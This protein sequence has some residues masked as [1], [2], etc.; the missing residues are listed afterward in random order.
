MN[1]IF[2][3][4]L[5]QINA[6]R[7]QNHE[8]TRL[9]IDRVSLFSLRGSREARIHTHWGADTEIILG[10]R[11]YGVRGRDEHIHVC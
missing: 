4:I 10:L 7:L 6:Q 8:P 2:T 1:R 9:Y 5:A 11:V 3:A